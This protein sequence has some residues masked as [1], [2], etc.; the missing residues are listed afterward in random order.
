[1]GPPMMWVTDTGTG[2]ETDRLTVN[3]TPGF[4]WLEKFAPSYF[5]TDG[6][7][8]SFAAP[9]GYSCVTAFDGIE[10]LTLDGGDG[11]DI[12]R[13]PGPVDTIIRGGGGNDSIYIADTSGAITV[14]GGDGSDTVTVQFGN[15]T[16]PVTVQDS[17][18][19][20]SDTLQVLP[21]EGGPALTATGTSVSQG[22]QTVT[23]KP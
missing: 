5:G 9:F 15:I 6:H 19:T 17:G 23:A 10:S 13:D 14:D 8:E 18:T 16:G 2:A 11:D 7:V 22:S 21:A 20:G 3:G 1:L 12:I 4:D